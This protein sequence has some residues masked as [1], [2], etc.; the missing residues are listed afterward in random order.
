MTESGQKTVKNARMGRKV[1]DGS[2]AAAGASGRQSVRPRGR[3]PASGRT[4][5]ADGQGRRSTKA[6]LMDVAEILIAQHG[7]DGVSLRD[8]GLLAGQANSNVI[9]YHF[10][11]KLGLVFAIL[12]DRNSKRESMRRD[13]FDEL[14][15]NGDLLN[16]RKLLEILWVPSLNFI[17]PDGIH[18][19]C[20]FLMQC[21]LHPEFSKR[22]RHEDRDATAIIVDAI[23]QLRRIYR[24]I[25][26]E[27]FRLRLAA[28]TRM[29]ISSVVEHDKAREVNPLAGEFDLGPY[30]D[31]A[32]AALAAP[33][34]ASGPDP[35]VEPVPVVSIQ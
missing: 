35:K 1:A 19:Y 2:D 14:K 8:I 34:S 15:K 31:I 4:A 21:R 26:D 28:L 17:S 10:A 30:L 3:R 24:G 6:K 5:T 13:M 32:I 11:N 20:H 18:I 22:K 27:L 25:S 33:P 29:F 16:P 23:G 9:Q 7:V 12:N